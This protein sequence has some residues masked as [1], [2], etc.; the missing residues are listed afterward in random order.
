MRVE[1]LIVKLTLYYS[2]IHSNRIDGMMKRIKVLWVFLLVTCGD[3]K[4]K[5][6]KKEKMKSK[7]EEREREWTERVEN[8]DSI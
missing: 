2:Y 7:E 4:F 5:E 3:R 1:K 8:G 6:K